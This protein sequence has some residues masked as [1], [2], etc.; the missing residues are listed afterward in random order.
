MKN[1]NRNAN[2]DVYMT[3]KHWEQEYRR[4]Y[5]ARLRRQ[6]K[7]KMI[8]TLKVCAFGCLMLVAGAVAGTSDFYD[9][10]G[11]ITRDGIYLEDKIGSF[12]RLNDGNK[13]NVSG[14]NYKAGTKVRLTLDANGT[15]N[16][17]RDDTVIEVTRRIF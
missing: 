12:V 8:N 3:R 4:K 14:Y 17:Y 7:R 11:Y 9:E 13:F 6:R 5:E 2:E 1:A 15:L 10:T 16:D